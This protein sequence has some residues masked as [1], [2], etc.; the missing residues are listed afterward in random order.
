MTENDG[1]EDALHQQLQVALTAAGRVAEAIA[2]VREQQQKRGAAESEARGRDLHARFDAQRDAA[3]VHYPLVDNPQ[4]WE[5]GS[6]TEIS[7]VYGMAAAW[8]DYD[9]E[10]ARAEQRIVDEV[11]SRYG[12]DVRATAPAELGDRL[13]TAADELARQ[14]DVDL[15]EGAALLAAADRADQLAAEAHDDERGATTPEEELHAGQ[16]A[17]QHEHEAADLEQRGEV[18]YDTAERRA[19]TAEDLSRNVESSEGVEAKML[20]DVSQGAPAKQ[21]THGK[22]ARAKA[23]PTR[24]KGQS[25]QQ[26][27]GLSR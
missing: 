25:K 15:V 3:R 7:Q 5:H 11:Q 8:K 22:Q 19:A 6:R 14:A 27:R 26:Q 2:R 21:A 24:G 1:I 9:P 4:W 18:A 13:S 16:E 23:R 12:I 10:A 17:E 20:A